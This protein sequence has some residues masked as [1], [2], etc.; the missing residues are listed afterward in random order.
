MKE[1]RDRSKK[2]SAADICFGLDRY[3]DERSLRM[4]LQRFA[5]D[6]VLDVIIP[7]LEDEELGEI[8]AFVSDILHHHLNKKEYHYLFLNGRE[9]SF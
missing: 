1:K 5:E 9:E 8:V 2:Y 7:R 6:A 4:F 3:T